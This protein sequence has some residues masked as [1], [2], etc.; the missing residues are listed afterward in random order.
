[1]PSVSPSFD[2]PSGTSSLGRTRG[3]GGS[4]SATVL[5][6]LVALSLGRAGQVPAAAATCALEGTG[7][8]ATPFLVEAPEDLALVGVGACGLG[9]EYRQTGDITLAPPSG[10]ATS[11]HTPIALSSP[12]IGFSGTYDGGE[13]RIT[14]LV[15]SIDEEAVGLFAVTIGATIRGVHIDGGSVA[16]W[17]TKRQIGGL[18]GRANNTTIERS[19]SSAAVSGW[20]EVGGLVGE[21]FN[22]TS[23]TAA[24]ATGAVTVTAGSTGTAG[25]LVGRMAGGVVDRSSAAGDVTG[26][27]TVGG[28][29]G[30]FGAVGSDTAQVVD[31]S[32]SGDVTAGGNT[33]GLIGDL[34]SATQV[35]RS[36]ASGDVTGTFSTGGLVGSMSQTAMVIESSAG[37]AVIGTESVGGLV[38]SMG[39]STL[40]TGSLATGDVMGS[41]SN[42]GGLVGQA[43]GGGELVIS[44]SFASGSVSGASM[45]GGLVGGLN[46]ATAR[47][48]SSFATGPVT[49]P[50]SGGFSVGGLVGSLMDASVSDSFATGSVS[51]DFHLGG[52]IGNA[53]GSIAN[54]FA[55]GAV[56][57]SASRGG[58]VGSL[59]FGGPVVVTDSFWDEGTTGLT[60]SAGG[61]RKSTTQLRSFAT[62]S[63]LE[64]AGLDTA[65]PIVEGW[66]LYGPDASPARKWGICSGVNGGYPFLL[67]RF[68][69]DP[70]GAPTGGDDGDGDGDAAAGAGG[71]DAMGGPST[72]SDDDMVAAPPSGGDEDPGPAENAQVVLQC[73]P[74]PPQVG[75]EVTC[76]VSGGDPGIAILWRASYNPLIASSGVVLDA[77][78]VGRFA[79]I[80]PTSAL[81]SEVTVELVEWA[82]PMSLGS[83]RAAIPTQVP[84]GEGSPLGPVPLLLVL[85]VLGMLRRRSSGRRGWPG[86]R[87]APAST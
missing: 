6:L 11:N 2:R 82:P 20:T 30:F 36:S 57:G 79:F 38:G 71:D 56:T 7:S 65:W 1:V 81:G 18:V 39:G 37:G 12:T 4:R 75:E 3:R 64:T 28:L 24:S 62:F 27:A 61:T 19:S 35:I 72:D 54:A 45:V 49:A 66:A 43:F 73:A 69:T 51:G 22:G 53:R 8:T 40:V 46:H 52:L 33:G 63:A 21:A 47:V 85:A 84:A 17:S 44:T 25:G 68:G 83:A 48:T 70:C 9:A 60:T 55:T 74:A 10:G 76:A 31:S 14:G 15:I 77:Q 16:G 41:S 5:L 29:L 34:R 58:L 59:L 86:I 87:A 26:G 78:G 32:A 23:I 42:I 50:A 67:W 80:V 13:H